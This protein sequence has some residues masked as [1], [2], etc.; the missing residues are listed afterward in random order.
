VWQ[1]P[2]WWSTVGGLELR[3]IFSRLWTTVHQ[4]K[5][6]CAGV[7]VVFN[8]VFRLTLSCC[9][10]EIFTITPRSWPHF[11][12]F[13]P[14]NFGGK[15]PPK[16]LT[17]FHKSWWPPNM[18]QSL[19]TI[20]QR[21]SKRLGCEQMN[22]KDLNYSSKTEWPVAS[23]NWWATIIITLPLRLLKNGM[24]LK[25]QNCGSFSLFYVQRRDT[26]YIHFSSWSEW[27]RDSWSSEPGEALS[28]WRC[29]GCLFRYITAWRR[30][31]HGSMQPSSESESVSTDTQEQIEYHIKNHH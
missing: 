9:I 19:V 4:I 11:D 2:A 8:A 31:I 12:V 30:L 3:S 15:E 7:S 25:V 17:E 23:Y 14:L 13:G 6:A 28:T 1:C 20:G 24:V 26:V 21:N 22:N 27:R 5:Y 18:W 10:P 16:F 29:S